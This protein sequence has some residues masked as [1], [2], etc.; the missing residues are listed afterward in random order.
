MKKI[1]VPVDFSKCSDIALQQ[2]SRIAKVLSAEVH[3]Y[4]VASLH[5]YWRDLSTSDKAAYKEN[6]ELASKIEENLLSRKSKLLSQGVEVKV[7]YNHG[8][9]IENII[10]YSTTNEVDLMVIGTHGMSG[11]KEWMI[12]SNAQ[13]ILRN[14]TC[15]VIAIKQTPVNKGF[16]QIAFV[17]DFHEGN[18]AAFNK[19]LDFAKAFNSGVTIINMDEPGFFSDPVLVI[20]K[21]MREFQ[22]VAKSRGLNCD[23]KRI[24]DDGFEEGLRKQIKENE[25]DLVVIPTHGRGPI[26][27]LFLSSI[28][29]AV[30]NHMQTPVMTIRI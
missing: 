19:T 28:A 6:E 7:S 30:V 18:M 4:H 3:L 14:V 15:P 5:P 22:D 26:A 10:K 13:K 17:S 23:I 27:R 8:H 1:L 12:G 24:T 9:V 25:I 21:A 11:Y 2:A 29:E 16:D 20:K